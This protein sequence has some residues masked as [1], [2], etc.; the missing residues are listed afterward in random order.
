MTRPPATVTSCQV[1]SPSNC[2]RYALRAGT[3]RSSLWA[4]FQWATVAPNPDSAGLDVATGAEAGAAVAAL[5][6]AADLPGSPADLL[7]VPEHPETA[8]MIA[9]T[10]STATACT[11]IGCRL[12]RRR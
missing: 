11:G 10:T 6:G 1:S 7:A 5:D 12:R 8:P 9:A 4:A 2:G 3:E